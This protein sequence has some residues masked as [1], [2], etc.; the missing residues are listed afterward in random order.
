MPTTGALP[1]ST[2]DVLCFLGYLL[3]ED[4]KLMAGVSYQCMFHMPDMAWQQSCIVKHN[5]H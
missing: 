3:G 4:V 1:L 2:L 5:S